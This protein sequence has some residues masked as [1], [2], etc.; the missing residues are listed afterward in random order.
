[1]RAEAVT[2]F[3]QL[4]D[5]LAFAPDWAAGVLMLALAALLAILVYGIAL[6]ALRRAIRPQHA[7][8]RSLIEA[9]KRP[10]RAALVI[11]ALG[12][13][14]QAAR[15]DPE[16]A[17]ALTQGLVVAFAILLGWMASIAVKLAA[18]LYLGRFELE[19][20][21]NLLAR[22]HYTQVRI[23]ERAAQTLVIVIAA[24]GVLMTF[25]AVRQYG[26][27]LF[28][29]AGVAGIVIGLAARPVL[30][31]LIAGLQI[32]VTQPIRIDDVVIVEGEYGT[33][34]EITSTYVVVKIWDL[35]RLIVPLSHFIEKPFENWTREGAALVGS[36][37]LHVDHTTP[38][39]RVREKLKEIVKES[40]FWDG[41]TAELQVTDSKEYTIELRATVSA[42]SSGAA[43]NLRCEVR[44]KLIAFLQAE[45]PE[46]LPRR[47]NEAVAAAAGRGE[48][49]QK[50][51]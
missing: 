42:R 26:V 22:K 9:I 32:A 27:S 39:E 49:Q 25:D 34:E 33:I 10:A 1:M 51:A 17:A 45:Y 19:S 31:N 40:K 50:S 12:A 36:V 15:F 24:G 48:R 4:R 20:A 6:M 44:E 41:K 43:W 35:R 3:S 28:A 7:F 14:L 21:D 30:S 29:S 47:R 23:L 37:F 5:A 11:F 46:A 16:A 8:L 13:A 18:D 2:L 38:V